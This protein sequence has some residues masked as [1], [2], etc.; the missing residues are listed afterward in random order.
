[1]GDLVKTVPEFTIDYDLEGPENGKGLGIILKIEW[2]KF[3]GFDL[4][5][6]LWSSGNVHMLPVSKFVLLDR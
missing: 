4:A 5:T 1:M 6:V 2:S 3:F